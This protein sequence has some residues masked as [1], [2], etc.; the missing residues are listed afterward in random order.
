V[1]VSPTPQ[2]RGSTA[3]PAYGAFSRQRRRHTKA[4]SRGTSGVQAYDARPRSAGSRPPRPGLPPA[5]EPHRSDAG[6][7]GP[8]SA[9]AAPWPSARSPRSPPQAPLNVRLP[10]LGAEVTP[11]CASDLRPAKRHERRLATPGPHA[12]LRMRGRKRSRGSSLVGSPRPSRPRE[13]QRWGYGNSW[14]SP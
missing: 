5:R 3:R 6:V 2:G 10:M 9:P 11:G 4:P 13:R 14:R 8:S 7:D 12:V 1:R